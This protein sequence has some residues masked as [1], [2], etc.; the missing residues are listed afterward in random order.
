SGR[1]LSAPDTDGPL[2]Q[3]DRRLD[4]RRQVERDLAAKVKALL[5]DLVGSQNVRVEVAAQLDF[6]HVLR[7]S[8]SFDPARQVVISEQSS[9][10]V[11]VPETP[12][13]PGSNTT[14]TNYQNTLSIESVERAIGTVTRLSVAV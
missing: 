1:V 3:A 4:Y 12:V 14:T 8:E 2:G 5:G 7:R 6:D 10:S 11:V 9:E 13:V